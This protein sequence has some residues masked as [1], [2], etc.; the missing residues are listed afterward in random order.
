MFEKCLDCVG[1]T[2]SKK[3]DKL[4]SRPLWRKWTTRKRNADNFHGRT[5]PVGQKPSAILPSPT[6]GQSDNGSS[7]ETQTQ[8][9]G[10]EVKT[11]K[12]T[13]WTFIPR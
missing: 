12:Y 7:N 5:I 4:K 11:S 13:I 2:G 10:N 1:L 3:V 9:V 6:S 8:F